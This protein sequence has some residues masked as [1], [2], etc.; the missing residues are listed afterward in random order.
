MILLLCA[1]WLLIFVDSSKQLLPGR[2]APAVWLHSGHFPVFLSTSFSPCWPP[3]FYSSQHHL[4][5]AF[6]LSYASSCLWKLTGRLPPILIR[7]VFGSSP[8]CVWSY[9]TCTAETQWGISTPALLVD[10]TLPCPSVP[11]TL[12][13]PALARASAGTPHIWSSLPGIL[14][15]LQRCWT[16]FL[17]GAFAVSSSCNLLFPHLVGAVILQV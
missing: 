9:R 14:P 8:P 7:L 10:S 15:E 2:P 6:P 13:G 17:L 12:C 16:P 3:A 4:L 1:F 11:R 5:L